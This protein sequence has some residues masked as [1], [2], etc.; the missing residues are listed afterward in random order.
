MWPEP[1]DKALNLAPFH[2]ALYYDVKRSG[3]PNYMSVKRQVPSQLNCTE[4][5]R[6]LV[7]YS[8]NSIVDF[9]RY[10][11]P[12]SYTA[13]APPV[14]TLQNH[15]SALR[16]P[17]AVDK[18]ITKEL[19][20]EALLGPFGAPPFVPWTQVS[21]LMTRDKPDGS[22]KR[23]IIDLSYPQGGSVN[24]GIPKNFHQGEHLAYTLPSAQDL[25]DHMLAAGKGC[26]MWKSDLERAYRQLR[27]DPL[28]YPLLAIRHKGSIYIDICPSFG[29]RASSSAQQLVSNAVTFLM[30]ADNFSTLAYVDDFCGIAPTKH[31]AEESFRAFHALTADLGLKLAKDKTHPPATK[32]EWLGYEFDSELMQITIPHQKMQE[33]LQEL[34][35]W[36]DAQWAT[37]TQ[38]QSL[39]GKL[40][41]IGNCVRPARRFM[42]RILH[43]LR[44]ANL[45]PR[46]RLSPEFMKDVA[47]FT[48]FARKF[49]RKLL[50][51]PK[52]SCITFE[53]DACPK[54]CG[55]F[56]NSL[57]YDIPFPEQYA[58]RFHISQ[59]EALNAV[60]A[61]K[62]LT[63]PNYTDGRILVKTDN[64]GSVYALSTG[65]TKDAVLAACA[66]EL[67]LF[68]ALRNVDILI[69]HTPGEQLQLADAL[70]RMSFNPVMH[71]RAVS[72]VANLK[73][74]RAVPV[75]LTHVLSASL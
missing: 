64:M 25:A 39:A 41:F 16:N 70:S 4:W 36:E 32:M 50:I 27:V 37:K 17:D 55:G 18:F 15:A 5:E 59:L 26:F 3:L 49:N 30:E 61:V 8:D 10:G 74:M 28:D 22:G 75:A 57:Y 33:V 60:I 67:W 20:K 6:R 23:V 29:C 51:E 24:D 73:L 69:T 44:Q 53:C 34:A 7:G 56:S 46:V 40:N 65:R 71:D 1:T 9:L 13:G 63:P 48:L 11:W 38:L 66:R 35:R 43:T 52:K 62:T 31:A 14:A 68:S 54:G 45:A 2:M 19:S 21:P 47:W 58:A 12:V 72:S 42:N